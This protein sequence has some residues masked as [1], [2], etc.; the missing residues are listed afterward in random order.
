MDSLPERIV[1]NDHDFR[2]ACI[3]LARQNLVAL[4]TEFVGEETYKPE[5][6]LVQIA[7]PEELILIDTIKVKNI[8]PLWKLLVEPQREVV[9]HAG[10]EE[11]RLCQLAI[12]QAPANLFDIQIAAGLVGLGF[13]LG[14]APLLQ[15]TINKRINKAETLTDWRVR[16]LTS[17]QV[18]YAFDDVRYL[19]AA[20]AV[21]VQRLKQM[22]RLECAKEE[23]GRLLTWNPD[24]EGE[25]GTEK[26]RRLRGASQ[27]DRRKLACLKMIFDWREK[28]ASKLNR[29]ARSLMRDDL[30]IEV[31][32]R[33]PTGERDLTLVRGLQSRDIPD[34]VEMANLARK[35]PIEQCPEPP[36]KDIE[37]P[38]MTIASGVLGAVLGDICV[39]QKMAQSLVASVAEIRAIVRARAMKKPLPEGLSL[40]EGWRRK[41]VWPLI[42]AVLDGKRLVRLKGFG[43]ETPIE[44]QLPTPAEPSP[45]PVAEEPSGTPA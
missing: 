37:T 45:A 43:G 14:M 19:L 31:A 3:R 38:S 1:A 32:R 16:P 11:I 13:P 6:C 39:R 27:L 15:A 42:E 29:P 35:M 34:L 12:G 40:L 22:D 17:A 33:M 26:W 44:Y 2:G 5:I 10:K 7:T 25:P 21:L 20:H 41:L 28:R 4:D 9:V 36:E 24:E 23:F 18:R 30:V 8:E